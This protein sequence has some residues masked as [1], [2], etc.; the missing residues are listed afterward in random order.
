M[1]KNY[2]R[3]HKKRKGRRTMKGGDAWDKWNTYTGYLSNEIDEW[4]AKTEGV[5]SFDAFGARIT[6]FIASIIGGVT[7][8]GAWGKWVRDN[9]DKIKEAI[10]QF[11]QNPA[12][13]RTFVN[14]VQYMGVFLGGYV[15]LDLAG[16][17]GAFGSAI[18][19][20]FNSTMWT[21]LCS[22]FATFFGFLLFP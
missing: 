16:S 4:V 3:N 5:W 22:I 19:A 8:T 6:Q 9:I 15:I 10:I 17:S 13:W 11:F 1:K 7:G 21:T 20:T 12:A 14:V 18:S 2:T